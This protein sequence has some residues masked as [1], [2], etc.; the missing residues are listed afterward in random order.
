[1]INYSHLVQSDDGAVMVKG[2]RVEKNGEGE[3]EG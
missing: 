2:C 1:M 3:R